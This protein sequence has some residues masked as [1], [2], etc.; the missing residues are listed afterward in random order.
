MPENIFLRRSPKSEVLEEIRVPLMAGFSCLD[1]RLEDL[2]VLVQDD[3]LTARFNAVIIV[4]DKH[5]CAQFT[6][7]LN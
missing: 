1:V 3:S 7:I 2:G 6:S 5:F 4:Y